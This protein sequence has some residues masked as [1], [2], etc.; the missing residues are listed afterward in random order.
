MRRHE[1][2]PV[3]LFSG[4]VFLLIAA[5]YALTHT[6]DTR[7]NWLVA[8][9]VVLLVAGSAITLLAVRRIAA[10]R[11]QSTAAADPDT[12]VA[13]EPDAADGPDTTFSGLV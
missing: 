11:R 9:P 12:G 8:I 2:D 4:L 7:L 5:G 6:T 3:S 10:G 1:L 13:S